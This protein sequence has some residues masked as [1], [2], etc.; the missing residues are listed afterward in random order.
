VRPRAASPERRTHERRLSELG[1]R[2]RLATQFE[3]GWLC[4]SSGAETRRLAPI[5]EDWEDARDDLLERW[6][7]E[8][9]V[10]QKIFLQS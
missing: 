4:F 6:A 7:R 9:T 8:A 2:F 5:P 10:V 1:P 3:H